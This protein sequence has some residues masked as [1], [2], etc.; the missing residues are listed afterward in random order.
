MI[1]FE[2]PD[3]IDIDFKEEMDKIEELIGKSNF[4]VYQ[5]LKN[6]YRKEVEA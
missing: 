1:G 4:A 3:S 2:S 6:N 5:Y